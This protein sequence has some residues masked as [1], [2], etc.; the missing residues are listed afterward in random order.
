M[1]TIQEWWISNES[2]NKPNKT[3][4]CMLAISS[5]ML[6][7]RLCRQALVWCQKACVWAD[8]SVWVL[9]V[10]LLLAS[11]CLS[12]EHWQWWE[13]TG[14]RQR[15]SSQTIHHYGCNPFDHPSF[16][17]SLSI[18]LSPPVGLS[19]SVSAVSFLKSEKQMSGRRYGTWHT[20]FCLL[21]FSIWLIPPRHPHPTT[22]SLPTHSHAC[23]HTP[24]H[25]LL[26]LIPD[27]TDHG[28][29]PA[30]SLSGKLQW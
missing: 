14:W 29:T 18:A 21:S 1:Q 11:P 20:P 9:G 3:G 13:Q 4:K 24:T 15:P 22:P 2:H 25:S 30:A 19:V 7:L 12:A 8:R 23:V 17:L 10:H 5:F 16:S 28:G 26:P 27:K 6:A